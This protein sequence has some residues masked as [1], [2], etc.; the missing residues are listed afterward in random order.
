[1]IYDVVKGLLSNAI[2][3]TSLCIVTPAFIPLAFILILGFW[4]VKR[5]LR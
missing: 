5:S 3:I 2:Y 1:V 4:G